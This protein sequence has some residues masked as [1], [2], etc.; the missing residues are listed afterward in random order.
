MVNINKT[1]GHDTDIKLQKFVLQ[2]DV[3]Y[4]KLVVAKLILRT[5]FSNN[6]KIVRR[7]KEMS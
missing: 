4:G 3:Y 2:D 6:Y 1:D 5:T 7:T